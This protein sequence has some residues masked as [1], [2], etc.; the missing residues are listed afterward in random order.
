MQKK[1]PEKRKEIKHL[2]KEKSNKIET[3]LWNIKKIL[4]GKTK[5]GGER[6]RN[7]VS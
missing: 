7:A 6:K 2:M 3:W 4:Y 1:F 5:K